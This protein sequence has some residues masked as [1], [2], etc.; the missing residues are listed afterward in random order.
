MGGVASAFSE[1]VLS[2]SLSSSD[3]EEIEISAP[4]TSCGDA[5]F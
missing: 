4:F 5:P 3:E 1:S 2:E